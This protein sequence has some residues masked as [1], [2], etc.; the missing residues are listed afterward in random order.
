M[1]DAGTANASPAN[2]SRYNP[3]HVFLPDIV[4][5]GA[6]GALQTGIAND[7]NGKAGSR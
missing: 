6:N 1:F 3:L 7:A 4:R 5:A 2:P